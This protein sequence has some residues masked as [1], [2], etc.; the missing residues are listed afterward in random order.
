[1]ASGMKNHPYYPKDLKIPNLILNDIS[2]TK[3]LGI[4]FSVTFVALFS[5]WIFSGRK[6]HLK[7]RFLT[8][9]KICWFVACALIHGILEGYFSINHKTI[10]EDQSLLG[11]MCKFFFL[12]TGFDNY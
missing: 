6:E 7:G 3:L 1:M 9:M 4:F 8:R 12:S 5:T 11:Q 2:Y 10:P